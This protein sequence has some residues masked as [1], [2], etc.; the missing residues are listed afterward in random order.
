MSADGFARNV[1][2]AKFV[3][4]AVAVLWLAWKEIEFGFQRSPFV[5]VCLVPLHALLDIA[6]WHDL[7]FV[8]LCF[9]AAAT[10]VAAWSERCSSVSVMSRWNGMIFCSSVA[11]HF[12]VAQLDVKDLEADPTPLQDPVHKNSDFFCSFKYISC[13]HN[14]LRV[15]VWSVASTSWISRFSC[16]MFPFCIFHFLSHFPW[17]WIKFW[18]VSVFFYCKCCWP[19]HFS[20]LTLI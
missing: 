5:P 9:A 20:F 11:V 4:F 13:S 12:L 6:N 10:E 18:N 16:S 8:S 1:S 14:F 17:L 3:C 2:C 15:C 7:W 19:R